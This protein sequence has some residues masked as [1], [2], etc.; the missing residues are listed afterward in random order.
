VHALTFRL[1]LAALPLASIGVALAQP[2]EP[3]PYEANPYDL[4]APDREARP[5]VPEPTI[6][7]II[8]PMQNGML[9]IPGAEFVMGYDGLAIGESNERPAHLVHVNPFWIDR[10][11]VTVENM[12]ACAE[13]SE[14]TIRLGKGPL[15][16][17]DK[18][19]PKAAVNC[20]PWAAA[21]AYCRVVGKR[22]PTE[23]E[24]ELAA[25]GGQKYAYPWGSAPASCGNAVTLIG[26]RAGVS[27]SSRGPTAVGT[28]PRGASVYGV[29]D[30]AGNVEEW[31]ADWYTDRYEV[32][33]PDQKAAPS[34]AGPAFGVAHVLRGGGWMSRPRETRI[35]A[36]NWGSLNEVGANVG[37]RCA[38]D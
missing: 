18:G 34:P 27:C 21:D 16:T 31:V 7:R 29:E 11:E 8:V 14:C 13:R 5:R 17:L 22:L 20:V 36:R 32:P 2:E 23:A 26:N 3:N 33:L 15:C 4:Q 30:M 19:D 9:R 12:R 37:F 10:T 35:T 24:W 25:G 1:C 38:K 6:P 28:H